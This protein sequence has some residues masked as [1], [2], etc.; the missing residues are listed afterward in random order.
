[1]VDYNDQRRGRL[2]LISH[3]L[4]VVPYEAV[5]HDKV[6]L[7]KRDEPNGYVEPNYPYRFVPSK[8]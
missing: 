4:S 8:Y 1:V 5:P 6:K 3:F 2:N 7:P